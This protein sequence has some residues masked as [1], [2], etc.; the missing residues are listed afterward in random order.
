V[1][2]MKCSLIMIPNEIEAT[3]KFKDAINNINNVLDQETDELRLN[4]L[5][6]LSEIYFK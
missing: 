4:E 2:N 6:K 5:N 3:K 1:L